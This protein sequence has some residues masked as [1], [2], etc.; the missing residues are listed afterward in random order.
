M[1]HGRHSYGG[2][3]GNWYIKGDTIILA[4]EYIKLDRLDSIKTE[5]YFLKGR[6]LKLISDSVC[7][8][9]KYKKRISSSLQYYGERVEFTSRKIYR[10]L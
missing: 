3:N 7:G 5:S 4:Y 6:R 9:R 10:H 1:K 2:G 8:H